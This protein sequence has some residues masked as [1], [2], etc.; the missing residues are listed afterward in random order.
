MHAPPPAPLTEFPPDSSLSFELVTLLNFLRVHHSTYAYL[1]QLP[2]RP[3]PIPLPV[4]LDEPTIP[5]FHCLL[6][7][8]SFGN[9]LAVELLHTLLVD[10]V[11]AVGGR[12]EQLTRQLSA[13]FGF[14]LASRLLE[15]V[16]P[17]EDDLTAAVGGEGC[18]GLLRESFDSVSVILADSIIS[19]QWQL[20]ESERSR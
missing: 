9:T 3:V 19:V 17:S 12:E 6:R 14:D 7:T 11:V 20:K 4:S 13:E 16:E 15:D 5:L 2:S 10:A 18:F 1:F 8:A